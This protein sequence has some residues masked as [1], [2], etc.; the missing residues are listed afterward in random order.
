MKKGFLNAFLI[1]YLVILGATSAASAQAGSAEQARLQRNLDIMELV[2]D[3]LLEVQSAPGLRWS[4]PATRATYLPGFGVLFKVPSAQNVSIF[5]FGRETRGNSARV[6]QEYFASG[7]GAATN[8]LPEEAGREE[9]ILDFFAHWTGTLDDLNEN[10]QIAIYRDSRPEVSAFF[11]LG[12]GTRRRVESGEEEMLALV[13]QPDLA[14]LHTGKLDRAQF[15]ARM[16]SKKMNADDHDLSRIAAAIGRAVSNRAGEARGI[17]LE[18]YGAVFFTNAQLGRSFMGNF[19]FDDEAENPEKAGNFEEFKTAAQ[20]MA[21]LK[22][23]AEQHAQRMQIVV[24]ERQQNWQSEYSQLKNKLIDIVTQQSPSLPRLQPQK[25]IVLVTD[26]L[27][28]PSHQPNQLIYR[29]KKQ[30]AE[31]FNAQKISREQLLKKISYTEN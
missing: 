22:R 26:L 2:L 20:I 25:W 24:N 23:R 7:S 21:E 30:D 3:R 10:E 17:Y 16:Q 11:D 6:R 8:M 15:S 14:A 1:S 5:E 19:W 12:G 9:A 18:N 31:D 4:A 27:D 13:R 29:I 28:A